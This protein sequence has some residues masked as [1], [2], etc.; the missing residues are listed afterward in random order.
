MSQS[1]PSVLFVAS[2]TPASLGV[3]ISDQ[4]PK[5]IDAQLLREVDVVVTL[6]REAHVD[7]VAGTRFENWDTDEPSVR[8]SG[9]MGNGRR[10]ARKGVP[11]G[12]VLRCCTARRTASR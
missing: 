4:R 1:K 5:P 10:R 12:W 7:A 2:R 3:D 8:K 11:Y 9:G 6:G